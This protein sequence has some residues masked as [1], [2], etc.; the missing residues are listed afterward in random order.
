M[1]GLVLSPGVEPRAALKPAA[2]DPQHVDHDR[3]EIAATNLGGESD[4]RRFVAQLLPVLG[5]PALDQGLGG[6]K[7]VGIVVEP[8]HQRR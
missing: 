5:G 2:R 4:E 6:A 7:R 1:D 3:P 8:D